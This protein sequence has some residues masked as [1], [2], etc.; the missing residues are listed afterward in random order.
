LSEGMSGVCKRRIH[1]QVK[2]FVGWQT[3]LNLKDI[4]TRCSVASVSSKC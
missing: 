4:G 1:A 2:E 3:K